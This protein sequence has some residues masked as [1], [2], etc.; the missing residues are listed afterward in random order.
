MKKVLNILGLVT[1]FASAILMVV[2]I[3]LDNDK[4]ESIGVLLL[5]LSYFFELSKNLSILK[6]TEN[7]KK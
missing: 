7:G 1:L 6:C 2:A 4:V 3:T 5:A